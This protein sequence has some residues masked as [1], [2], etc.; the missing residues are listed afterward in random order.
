MG[1]ND[2]GDRQR[3]QFVE[4]LDPAEVSTDHGFVA[5]APRRTRLPIDD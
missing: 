4:L 3:P 2:S 1:E 5:Q